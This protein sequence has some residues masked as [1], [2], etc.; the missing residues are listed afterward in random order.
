M[1]AP[2]APTDPLL[3][4][5]L[6]L[7]RRFDRPTT[8]AALTA[9]LPL[10]EDHRLTPELALRAAERAGI[11]AEWVETPLEKLHPVDLPAILLLD[12]GEAAVLLSVDDGEATLH[13]PGQGD[14]AHPITQLSNS[15]AGRAL[16]A[17]PAYEFD[18]RSAEHKEKRTGHWL[19]RVLVRSWPLYV[20]VVVASLLV[21]LFTLATPYFIMNVYDRVV[22]NHAVE[23]LWVLASG[24]ALV[25]LF[26]V[27]IRTL[28][29]HFIDSAGKRADVILGAK[30]FAHI[31]H[32]PLKGQPRSVGAFANH[33]HEFEA[34][35]D[36]VTSAT[37]TTLI[38]LPFVLLFLAVIGWVA[39]PV[40]LV[41]AV[42]APLVILGGLALQPPLRRLVERGY[43]GAADRHAVLIESLGALPTIKALGAEGQVQARWEAVSAELAR[44]GLRTRF[45]QAVALHFALLSQQFA[46]L[47]VVLYGVY[48]ITAGEMSVGALIAC[49]LL[50]GRALGPLG[51]VAG[52]L[53]RYHQSVASLHALDRIFA[54]PTERPEGTR[55]LH[56]PKL[57]GGVEFREVR[58]SYPEQPMA[59]LD[60]VS[61]TIRPGERVGIV[62]P[63]GC[64]K[65]TVLR[66]IQGLYHAD[67]GAVLIDGVDLRQL[68]PAEL[69]RNIGAVPQEVELM[70]G[71]VRDN[72]R[73]GTPWA[74]D[75]AVLAAAETAGVSAFVNEHPAGFA[76]EVGEGGRLLSGGQRQAV[77]VARAVLRDPP[78]LLL[79][80]PTSSMDSAAEE[81]LKRRLAESTW[82]KT[83][84]L[85]SHRASVL[86]LVERLIVIDHGRVTADGP[87][88]QVL[89]KLSAGGGEGRG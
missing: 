33:F 17:R 82:G 71:S 18:E 1:A 46:V 62:G 36:F 52:L 65:S 83:V 37:L 87:K 13:R 56:R 14:Q 39:G 5:L 59:T 48:R 8:P 72:I 20:E 23:T 86:S 21:N 41:P 60:G 42:A 69:R 6:F 34:L 28:R 51:Q 35:R 54:Q 78:L 40:A 43:R 31:L 88:E 15:Y 49:T 26:D 45:V 64:G 68:D 67:Q 61:F 25:F 27:L 11:E 10:A 29:V 47:G 2:S 75:E 9:G 12:Q 16:R 44:T 77:A 79:D 76:L 63:L 30:L 53:T 32:T 66:L 81:R 24:L 22:P 4:C 19:W 73:F 58:F 55:P 85:V 70:A 57:A 89:R 38:D 84:L 74:D 7:A 80:E 50:T 3:E